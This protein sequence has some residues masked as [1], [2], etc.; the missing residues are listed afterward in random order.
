MA[1]YGGVG[2]CARFHCP[3]IVSRGYNHSVYPI[4]YS[5]VVRGRPVWVS[6]RELISEDYTIYNILPAYGFF[7]KHRSCS[8]YAVGC[9]VAQ[10]SQ[11][12]SSA[13][14]FLYVRCKFLAH[15]VHGVCTHGVKNIYYNVGHNHRSLSA[16]Y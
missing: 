10:N 16:V 2:M 6:I 13:T 12:N 11:I 8:R 9:E 7:I 15:S 1:F 14:P 4:H 3:P 5:F